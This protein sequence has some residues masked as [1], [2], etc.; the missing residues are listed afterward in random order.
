M[1]EGQEKKNLVRFDFPPG[2]G[3]DEIAAAIRKAGYRLL[4][5]K[6]AREGKPAPSAPPEK[7]A[8]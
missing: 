4:A 1:A 6:A 8:E 2:A 7:A 5:E 3:P